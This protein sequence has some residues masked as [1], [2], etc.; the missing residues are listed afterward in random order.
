MAQRLDPRYPCD[1]ARRMNGRRESTDAALE[2]FI[3][4]TGDEVVSQR[5]TT[6]HQPRLSIVI[7]TWNREPV[8]RDAILALQRQTMKEFELIVVDNGPSTD[9]T[10]ASMLDFVASDPRITYV[11]TTR[12]GDFIARNIGCARARCDVILTIDDDW[13][14]T[15]PA[16]LAYILERFAED[17]RLGVLGL[18]HDHGRELRSHPAWK[19]AA[20]R[21]IRAVYRPG[22][23]SRWGR[24]TTR[25]YYLPFGQRHR[26]DHV[27]GACMA[28]RRVPAS[29]ARYFPEFYVLDGMGYRSETD[30]C[31]LIQRQGYRIVFS[32]ECVGRHRAAPRE[33]GLQARAR[34]AVSVYQW[35]RNNAIFTLRH[36]WSP[37]TA[38]V[39][40]LYDL[41]IGNANQPGALRLLF[42]RRY[43]LRPSI[44]R[45]SLQGKLAGYRAFKDPSYR[46]A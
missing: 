40:L 3:D 12:K 41:L 6:I 7:P 11:S 19:K 16:S 2:R 32:T 25:F 45:P 9:S 36:F 33:Q 10:R 15:D 29:L 27:K 43:F 35:S 1:A 38:W 39:F 5:T 37:R 21:V 18:G 28:V 34:N 31:Q 46:I 23:V 14:M 20:Y 8:L 42:S 30:L 4:E 17:G 13:E 24:V 26:V 44:V 22:S